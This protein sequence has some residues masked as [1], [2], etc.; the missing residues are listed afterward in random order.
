MGFIY[1]VY[2]YVDVSLL[3]RCLSCADIFE[4]L[5]SPIV[6]AQNFLVSACSKRKAVLDPVMAMCVQVLELPPDQK[7]PRKKDGALNIIGQVAEVLMKVR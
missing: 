3:A 7:D 6:A 2:M 1:I 4:D 5:L